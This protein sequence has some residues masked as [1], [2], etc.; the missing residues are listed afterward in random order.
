[1]CQSRLD[2]IFLDALSKCFRS[3]SNSGFRIFTN[4]AEQGFLIRVVYMGVMVDQPRHNL[5]VIVS[6]VDGRY[7]IPELDPS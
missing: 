2:N 3:I 7:V 1:M 4:L 6:H 5:C